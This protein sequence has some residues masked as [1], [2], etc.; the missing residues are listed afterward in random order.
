MEN[1][2]ET[3]ADE[4]PLYHAE[5][6][7]EDWEYSDL[8][9]RP[10]VVLSVLEPDQLVATKER[11]RFGLRQMSVG[12]RAQLWTLRIYVIV[13]MIIVAVSVYRAIHPAH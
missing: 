6:M 9:V 2:P 4:L 10:E 11:T 13:M 12:L 8:A 3:K 5:P 7:Q 1:K